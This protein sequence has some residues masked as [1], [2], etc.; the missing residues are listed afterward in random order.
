MIFIGLDPGSRGACVCVDEN[1]SVRHQFAFKLNENDEF[2]MNYFIV[3]IKIIEERFQDE[4]FMFVLENVHSL[5][6]MSAKSNFNFG[7]NCGIIEAVIAAFGYSFVKVTPKDWQKE[8]LKGI[9]V[10]KVKKK[11]KYKEYDSEKLV[12]VDKTRLV[13]TKKNDVK[14]MSLQAQQ[15]LFPNFNSLASVRCKT[16]HDGL[17]DALLI[18]DYGRQI[19]CTTQR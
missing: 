5:F 2:D 8:Q 14:A 11:E 18:A 6:G 7:K 16:P 15:R 17:V 12:F 19:L 9:D 4:V 13:E 10:I 3:Q 1:R